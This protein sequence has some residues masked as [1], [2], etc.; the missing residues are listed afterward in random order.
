MLCSLRRRNHFNDI[1]RLSIGIDLRCEMKG[2]SR[3][4]RVQ[5]VQN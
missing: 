4:C 1:G 2:N 5:R 3:K